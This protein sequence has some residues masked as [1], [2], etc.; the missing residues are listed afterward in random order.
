M[1]PLS[2]ITFKEATWNWDENCQKYFER[3]KKTLSRETFLVYPNF[4]EPIEIHTG[5]SKSQFGAVISQN[6]KQ[7]AVYSR[8]LNPVHINYK[9]SERE[10]LEIVE[11][12][13]AFK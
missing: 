9:I 10:L 1:I 7:I 3:I 5:M 8:K 4:N 12:L 2:R 11:T 13:K 6:T